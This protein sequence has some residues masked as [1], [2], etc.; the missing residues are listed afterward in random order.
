[1]IRPI[2]AV[3]SIILGI[4]LLGLALAIPLNQGQAGPDATSAERNPAVLRGDSDVITRVGNDSCLARGCHGAVGPSDPTTGHF[5]FKGGEASTW[6]TFDPHARAYEVLLNSRSV[7][8][9]ERLKVEMNGQKPHRAK[10]C[11]VCHSPGLDVKFEEE[12]EHATVVVGAGVDCEACH[13][14]A[15]RWLS[16][17]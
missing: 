12:K 2:V 13:G 9:G 4:G 7:K 11:L 5:Y 10:L 17:R 3:R 6:R 8:I 14:N 16:S 15:S 1:M